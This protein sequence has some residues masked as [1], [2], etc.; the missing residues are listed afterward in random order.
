MDTLVIVVM[1]ANKNCR[2]PTGVSAAHVITSGLT[3]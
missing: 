2:I 3:E 1:P